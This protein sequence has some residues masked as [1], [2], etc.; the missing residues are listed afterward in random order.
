MSLGAALL[1]GL[2]GD[3]LFKRLRQFYRYDPGRNS[4]N[5]ITNNHDQ[6]RKQLTQVGLGRNVSVANRSQCNNR[7][8]DAFGYT[9]ETVF[10]IF[11]QINQ[12]TE[13]GHQC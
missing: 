5:T 7:P 4:D 11:D 12:R 1:A 2:S 9:G 13:Y 6:R 8:V 3:L 10:G